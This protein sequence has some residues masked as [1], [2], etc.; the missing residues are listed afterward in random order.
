MA[1][2]DGYSGKLMGIVTMPIKNPM[3]CYTG[4]YRELKYTCEVPC[5]SYNTKEKGM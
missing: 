5:I 1:A 2:A 3:T 4:W